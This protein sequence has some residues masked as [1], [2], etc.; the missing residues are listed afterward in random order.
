M[1]IKEE[2]LRQDNAD[3][4]KQLEMA[5]ESQTDLQ[6]KKLSM[7]LIHKGVL[8]DYDRLQSLHQMLTSDYE[9]AKY[10]NQSL[11]QKCKAE[12]VRES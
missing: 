5:V 9:T 12:K 8:K 11:K 6:K 7:E 4:K 3:M 2:L 10:E 1:Q